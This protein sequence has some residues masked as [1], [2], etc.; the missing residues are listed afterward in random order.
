MVRQ[1]LGRVD[2]RRMRYLESVFDR[3]TAAP[4]RARTLSRLS[5]AAFVGVHVLF[6]DVAKKTR[7]DM[8]RTLRRGLLAAAREDDS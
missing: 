7:R 3:I 1:V 2:R 8:G 6:G 4:G 5:Y